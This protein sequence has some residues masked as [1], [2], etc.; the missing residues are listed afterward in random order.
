MCKILHFATAPLQFNLEDERL[1]EEI[2]FW[3]F[4]DII[5]PSFHDRYLLNT[6]GVYPF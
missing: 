2:P 6:S 4:L 3:S 5:I 1:E